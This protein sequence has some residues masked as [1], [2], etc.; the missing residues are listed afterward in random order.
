MDWRVCLLGQF[1]IV[2]DGSGPVDHNL[3]LFLI[4]NGQTAHHN[5]GAALP[6]IAAI[7][8][9]HIGKGQHF[10]GAG[11]ILHGHIGHHGIVL[12]GLHFDLLNHTR[13]G[14]NAVIL[15]PAV[16]IHQ[17]PDGLY[18]C[19]FQVLP[20]VIHGVAGQV[21]PRCLLFHGHDLGPGGLL[22]IGHLNRNTGG[23]LLQHSEQAQLSL[24]V[25]AA[26]HRDGVH[27]GLVNG[28]KLTSA[29]AKAVH[30]AALNQILH[31]PLIQLPLAHALDKVFKGAEW[32]V[33]IPF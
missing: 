25:S 6:Q 14:Y 18:P 19:I 5:D 15:N 20:V 1:G 13:H 12:C 17:L 2:F 3:R 22:A 21:Q 7:L 11:I 29:Q 26:V 31:H 10:N 27:G 30:S 4:P 23:I 32:A 33:L 16:L 28:Q 9:Q 24:H 8:A